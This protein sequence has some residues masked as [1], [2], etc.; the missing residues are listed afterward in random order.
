MRN[1]SKTDLCQVRNVAFIDTNALYDTN[2]QLY[3]IRN[4]KYVLWNIVS[5]P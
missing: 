1:E 4:K 5:A 2:K 3:I